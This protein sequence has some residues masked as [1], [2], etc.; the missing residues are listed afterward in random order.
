MKLQP[1]TERQPIVLNNIF[2]DTNSSKLKSESYPELDKLVGMLQNE[3]QMKI[4]LLGHTDSI[5][6]EIDN[7]LLSENRAKSV[8]QYLID[9]GITPSR[10]S[11]QGLGEK[12]SRIK[13]H[14]RRQIHE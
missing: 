9:H 6:E 3:P 4:K 14:R 10:L 11:Y 1:I 7:Q 8:Y 2:F 13:R 5:G 12:T